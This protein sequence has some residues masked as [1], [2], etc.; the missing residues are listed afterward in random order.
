MWPVIKF[1]MQGK[2]TKSRFLGVEYVT[3]YSGV[4]NNH[5]EGIIVLK[6][7]VLGKL[8]VLMDYVLL[9]V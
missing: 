6:V 4:L 8:I 2:K 3:K 9:I 5:V 7:K 1:L